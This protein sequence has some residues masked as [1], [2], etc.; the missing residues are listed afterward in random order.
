MNGNDPVSQQDM[1]KRRIL[2]VSGIERL[3]TQA[4]DWCKIGKFPERRTI[5]VQPRSD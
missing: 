5:P 2:A 4:T 1:D 3:A